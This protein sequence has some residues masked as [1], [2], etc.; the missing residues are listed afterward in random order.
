MV[1]YPFY[2]EVDALMGQNVEIL[3][4]RQYEGK[5]IAMNKM[6]AKLGVEQNTKTGE[7]VKTDLVWLDEILNIGAI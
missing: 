4:D 5:V 2:A 6:F 7:W 1:T 3:A